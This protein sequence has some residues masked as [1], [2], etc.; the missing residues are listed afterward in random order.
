MN[1]SFLLILLQETSGLLGYFVG[2][3]MATGPRKNGRLR[4]EK[5]MKKGV[6]DGARVLYLA[7]TYAEQVMDHFVFAWLLPRDSKLG[8]E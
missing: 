2:Q 4:S 3:F 8:S 5:H 1:T 6:Q 7:S